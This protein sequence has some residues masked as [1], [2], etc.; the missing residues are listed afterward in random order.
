MTFDHVRTSQSERIGWLTL[1]RPETLNALTPQ[2]MDEIAAAMTAFSRDDDI[3]V[4]VITGQGR[5][6]CAGGDFDFLTEM[7]AAT[8]FEI[9]ET[10]YRHFG[11]GIQSIKLCPKPT[12]AAVNG[13]AVGA[14]C[15]IAL[16]CDFRVASENAM[17]RE[18]WIDLG[19]ISP[20]G[21]MVL[22]PRLIGLGRA[23]EMLLLGKSVAAREALEIGLVSDVVAPDQL[24]AR[25]GALAAQLA[26]GP[27]LG[28]R[29]MKEGIKRGL[30]AT[31]A[32]EWEHSIYVQSM[33]IGSHDF[34]EGVAAL[35]ER[36]QP[37]FKGA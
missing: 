10:V 26:Q 30:E 15:E 18:S 23:N 22:L 9:K 8:P 6:F 33:L 31:L 1:D 32:E 19:L 25:A 21:G 11:A 37:A 5:A 7:T 35:K 20:L 34:A 17:F 29:A 16:A 24:E 12:V 14:G 28:L 36:R 4:I 27:P 3:R 2:T 13:A